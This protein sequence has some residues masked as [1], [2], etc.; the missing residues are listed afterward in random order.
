MESNAKHR[1][2]TASHGFALQKS[3]SQQNGMHAKYAPGVNLSPADLCLRGEN[4]NPL[5]G[6]MA[7]VE[8]PPFWGSDYTPPGY[9]GMLLAGVPEVAFVML[10]LGQN[11]PAY[12]HPVGVGFG[13]A[14]CLGEHSL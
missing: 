2:E 9:D 13:M 10:I 11:C 14:D 7:C 8:S 4:G 3:G 6:E 1:T 5:N 12:Y